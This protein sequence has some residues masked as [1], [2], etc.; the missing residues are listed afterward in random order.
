M[1]TRLR[2]TASPLAVVALVALV[3]GCTGSPSDLPDPTALLTESSETTAE[4][5]SVHLELAVDGEI[6]GFAIQTL[7]GDLT[8]TPT[9]AAMGT[10]DAV[11][12]G[13]PLEAVEFVVFDG[14]LWVAL[15]SGG[16]L[17]NFGPASA[18]YDVAAI[19]DPD[20]GLANVLANFSDATADGRETV[21]GVDAVR[22]TGTVSADAV[23]QI[24]PQIAATGPVPATAWISADGDNELLQVRLEPSPD[25]SITMT[26]SQWGDPVIVVNPAG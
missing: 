11:V 14:A 20:T 6:P 26:L 2:R 9:V 17:S 12:F 13:Q 19:L 1:Q 23:N 8:Q 3:A 25:N 10:L 24:A 16:G 5:T 7:E 18:I 4:Q 22:V 15:T 21:G